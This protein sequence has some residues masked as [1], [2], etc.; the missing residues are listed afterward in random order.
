MTFELDVSIFMHLSRASGPV[1]VWA[2]QEADERDEW[3][4]P[5]AQDGA[6]GRFHEQ[7]PCET[8]GTDTNIQ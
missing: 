4:G 3:A 7:V 8:D 2:H 5:R 1:W 6:Q